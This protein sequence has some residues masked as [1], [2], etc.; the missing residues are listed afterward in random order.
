[1]LAFLML[2]YFSMLLLGLAISGFVLSRHF[3]FMLLSVEL[4]LISAIV[5]LV[6]FLAYLQV[7]GEGI[8]L[9]FSIWAISAV[10]AIMAVAFFIYIKREGYNFDVSKLSKMRW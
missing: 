6:D 3:V 4:V 7:S 5:L 9:L 10:D 8:M 1:M 2:A